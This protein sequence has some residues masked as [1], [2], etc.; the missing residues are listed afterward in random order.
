MKTQ[1]HKF[2]ERQIQAWYE[3]EEVRQS[4]AVNMMS[5]Q[6]RDMCDLSREEHLFV[7]QNYEALKQ[8]AESE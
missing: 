1:Q 2:T 6:V 5:P 4:G 8:A 3:F 7:I